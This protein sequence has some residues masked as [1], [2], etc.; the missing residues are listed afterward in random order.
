M[1]APRVAWLSLR[2]ESPMG[3]NSAPDHHPFGW[4]ALLR[5]DVQP[6]DLDHAFCRRAGRKEPEVLPPAVHQVNVGRVV[7]LVVAIGCGDLPGTPSNWR[8]HS[9]RRRRCAKPGVTGPTRA[10]GSEQS[11]PQTKP[12]GAG[13]RIG[14]TMRSSK[15]ACRGRRRCMRPQAMTTAPGLLVLPMQL[16]RCSSP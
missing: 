3:L 11:V 14:R 6:D 16:E 13:C 8:A 2:A 5:C 4:A 15:S 1:P 7:D 10:L 12:A 9:G